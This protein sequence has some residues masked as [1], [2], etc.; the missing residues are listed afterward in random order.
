[1]GPDS[2]NI[3]LDKT[4]NLLQEICTASARELFLPIPVNKVCY[5]TGIA[6]N[7]KLRSL[8][9]ICPSRLAVEAQKINPRTNENLRVNIEGQISL[10]DGTRLQPTNWTF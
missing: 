9:E 7:A 6:Q 4:G 3:F 1:L 5:Q 2:E 10:N 8:S